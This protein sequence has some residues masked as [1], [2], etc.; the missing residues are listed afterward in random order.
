MNTATQTASTVLVVDDTRDNVRL[1]AR[2][3]GEHGYAVQFA[4]DGQT[5]LSLV[6]TTLPDVILLDIMMPDMNGYEVCTHLKSDERTRDIPVIFLSALNEALDKVKAFNVGGVDFISKPFQ[7]KEV[8][9]RV[10]THL[11]LRNMQKMLQQQNAELQRAKQAADA[12]NQAK[13][14]FLANMNHEL[15]TPLTGILG[16]VQILKRDP[17]TPA[18]QQ[19]ALT[20]IEQSGNHLLTL[21]NDVL[22]LAKVESGTIELYKTDFHLPSLIT[23]VSEIIRVRAKKKGIVFRVEVPTPGSTLTNSGQDSPEESLP[24][25]VHGDERRLRQILL[26]LLGNAVKF[27]ESGGTVTLRAYRHPMSDESLTTNIHFEVRDTGVGIASEDLDHIFAPFTQTG[28]VEQRAKGTGLGLAISR[29]LVELMDGTLQV[30][31]QLGE[32]STFWFELTLPEAFV[33]SLPVIGME[34]RIS[35]IIHCQNCAGRAPRVLVVDDN[36]EHRAVFVDLLKPL[37]FETAEASNGREGLTRTADFRPDLI[38]TDVMMPD[39]DGFEFIRH[40][41]R[42]EQQT[43]VPP[44]P[45][46]ATSSTSMY[47]EDHQ[48]SLEIG[49]SAFLPK[50]IEANLLFEQL[51]QLLGIEWQYQKTVSFEDETEVKAFIAP[52]AKTVKTLLDLAMMGD[53]EELQNRLKALAQSD[54]QMKPFVMRMQK[55]VQEFKINNLKEVL[56]EYLKI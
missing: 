37:G 41:R 45:I 15:R 24:A 9:A 43:P 22:D 40:I 34:Q 53:L 52:P 17:A 11:K 48:S 29:N 55:L 10:Q 46:I 7:E 20:V 35:G 5:A 16:Y 54:E 44:L 51:Q 28:N 38:I 56:Q 18:H 1:L 31:S 12:A 23:G 42:T 49:Y 3:L 27:T 6:L 25:Y 4:F 30:K 47:K 14:V 26:N 36:W 50:P 2:L 19:N 8:I 39:M 13:S 32:G 21:I 33:V